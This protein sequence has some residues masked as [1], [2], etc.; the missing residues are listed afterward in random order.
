MT[1]DERFG[2]VPDALRFQTDQWSRAFRSEGSGR[3]KSGFLPSPESNAVLYGD[4]SVQ[5]RVRAALAGVA[6]RA[7]ELQ[8]DEQLNG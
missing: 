4:K 1:T 3:S 8:A 6:S 5:G 2:H 7:R